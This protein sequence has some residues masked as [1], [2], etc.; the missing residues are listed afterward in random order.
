MKIF[1]SYDSRDTEIAQHLAS[2]LTEANFDVWWA[3]EEVL[4]G[5][6]WALKVGQAL[7]HADA[8]VVLISPAALH[9]STVRWEIRFALGSPSYSDRL[10][11]VLVKTTPPER[12][13]WILRK[14]RPIRFNPQDP[15]KAI[16]QIVERLS[17]TPV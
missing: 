11:P 9:S 1:L 6:N 16:Q 10:I 7:E 12:I 13:P 8:M 4:P 15:S 17:A 2:R 3:E 5:D 14:L